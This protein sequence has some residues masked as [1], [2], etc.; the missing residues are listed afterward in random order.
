MPFKITDITEAMVA[1]LKLTPAWVQ[2]FQSVTNVLA[3]SY[4]PIPMEDRFKSQVVKVVV[5]TTTG[6]LA[7]GNDGLICINTVDNTARLYADNAWRTV[8]SW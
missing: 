2:W 3:G 4:S 1:E 5:K 8:A 7:Y 6:D